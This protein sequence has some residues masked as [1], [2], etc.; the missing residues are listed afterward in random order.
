MNRANPRRWLLPSLLLLTLSAAVSAEVPQPV[1]PKPLKGEQCVEP[2]DD[3]RRNHMAYL[4]HDRNLTMREGIRGVKHSLK[5]CLDCHVPPAPTAASPQ[6][7]SDHFCLNCHRYAAVTIDCFDCHAT[8][9]ER[10]ES[11]AL[12]PTLLDPTALLSAT[13]AAQH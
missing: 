11:A 13:G 12:A 10:D 9:P 4:K 5:A 1:V 6:S 2:V 3:M 8:Q 7:L